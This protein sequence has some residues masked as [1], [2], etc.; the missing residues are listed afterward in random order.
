MLVKATI[1]Q[2]A[3]AERGGDGPPKNSNRMET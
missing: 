3:V 1:T 2:K